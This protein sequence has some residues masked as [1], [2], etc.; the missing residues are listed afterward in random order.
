VIRH[1]VI[2][3]LLM[4]STRPLPVLAQPRIAVGCPDDFTAHI[5]TR[6]PTALS[7]SAFAKY[8]AGLAE[9]QR[10]RVIRR[11]LLAG[12]LPAFLRHLKPVR[13]HYTSKTGNTI[14][15]VICVTPDYL[16][17]GSDGDFLRIPTNRYTALAV[18]QAFGFILPTRKM[19]DAIY[20]QAAYH[21]R[22][23][24]MTPGPR[25][26]SI[27]Y[28]LTHNQKIRRQRLAL[29]QP[30]GALVAGH[31]KDVVLTTRLYHQRQ[32]IAIYGWH[33]RTGQ[34]IQPLSTVHGARY[35]DYSHGI[36]LVS[37][38]VWVNGVWRSIYEILQDPRL[39]RVLSGEGGIRHLSTLM[40]LP[41]SF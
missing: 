41:T 8:V 30:L 16:A 22:P 20:E 33:R 36:R 26:R 18:A 2:M 13:L 6:Q 31:K 25:M 21:L 4:M 35:A 23:Q 15:A 3:L 29:G 24:P 10:E 9:P 17:I 32:R 11:Q 37:D 39:G 12:D 19:V 40:G 14:T 28:Y 1:V 27:S 7:G 5:P 38:M 34:P